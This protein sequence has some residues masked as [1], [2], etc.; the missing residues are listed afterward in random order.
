MKKVKK[1]MISLGAP[2]A[3]IAP[4]AIAISCGVEPKVQGDRVVVNHRTELVE[5]TVVED[6]NAEGANIVTPINEVQTV[7]SI[8]V[9]FAA[10]DKNGNLNVPFTDMAE[11][12]KEIAAK[13]KAANP[14]ETAKG[15]QDTVISIAGN[16][17]SLKDIQKIYSISLKDFA[18]E[19]KIVA[20]TQAL[21]TLA[22]NY[23]D[24]NSAATDPSSVAGSK[25]ND[26]L[27]QATPDAQVLKTLGLDAGAKAI[28]LNTTEKA[29]TDAIKTLITA[30]IAN[31][32]EVTANAN[33]PKKSDGSLKTWT[34]IQA[35]W[36]ND[37]NNVQD[38]NNLTPAETEARNVYLIDLAKELVLN[39]IVITPE[40]KPFFDAVIANK[41]A[42]TTFV[43]ET[44]IT[45]IT[46]A[47]EAVWTANKISDVQ[48]IIADA[49]KIVETTI[50][51]F[52]GMHN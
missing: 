2:L 15:Y 28:T 14:D 49:G 52:K 48:A 34:E 44:D 38:A 46:A 45:K 9:S 30:D 39:S 21:S 29:V 31:K 26:Y 25:L 43:T 17:V 7:W 37:K 40:Q 10:Y 22:Q 23:H 47:F 5:R 4:L 8:A 27:A 35:D 50:A 1:Y 32:K 16:K 6:P 13:V 24:L 11:A 3:V 20:L 12:A 42:M 33:W 51:V 41:T 36:T 18:D 19:T